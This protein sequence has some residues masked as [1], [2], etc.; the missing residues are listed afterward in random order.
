MLQVLTLV[1]GGAAFIRTAHGWKTVCALITVT[2]LHPEA[3]LTSLA[4]LN[5]IVR[6][7]AL[8]VVA[9]APVLETIVTSVERF[10]KVTA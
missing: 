9:F 5:S 10:A 2:S 1:A 8:G 4:A 7:P 3:A 6:P